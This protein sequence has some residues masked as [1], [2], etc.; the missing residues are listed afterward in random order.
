MHLI[1]AGA[2]N[3]ETKTEENRLTE[4]VVVREPLTVLSLPDFRTLLDSTDHRSAVAIKKQWQ[5]EG[6]PWYNFFEEIEIKPF[7]RED[8]AELIEKPIRGIFKLE[9]GLTDRIIEITEGKPYLIQ[10]LCIALV[11]RLYE[12]GRRRITLDDVEAVGRQ[13]AA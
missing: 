8:A 7:R 13:E 12:Q 2:P 4:A 1:A 9:D 10:K 3:P 11:N 6:S 5:R